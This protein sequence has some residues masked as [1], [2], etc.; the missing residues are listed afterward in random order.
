MPISALQARHEDARVI[1]KRGLQRCAFEAGARPNFPSAD[2]RGQT[3]H[4]TRSS[5]RRRSAISLT[6][7]WPACGGGNEPPKSRCACRAHAAEEAHRSRLDATAQ[8]RV[9]PSPRTRYLKLVNCSTRRSAR[10][11]ATRGDP[12]SAPKPNSPPS[13]NCVEALCGDDGRIHFVQKTL[14]ALSSSVTMQSV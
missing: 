10:V 14:R 4:Q 3:S 6:S 2:C 9:C 13:A 11:H 8:G 1:D 5:W 12:D 7:A